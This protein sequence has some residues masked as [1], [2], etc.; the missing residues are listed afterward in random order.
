MKVYLASVR[1][2]T[3]FRDAAVEAVRNLNSAMGVDF[4]W[5]IYPSENWGIAGDISTK[6]LQILDVE[7]VLID[8]TPQVHSMPGPPIRRVV[9]FNPD[10]MTEYGIAFGLGKLNPS[11]LGMSNLTQQL[12]RPAHKI[13]CA[14]SYPRHDLPAIANGEDVESYD[15]DPG[16]RHE[17]VTKLQREIGRNIGNAL[18]PDNPPLQQPIPPSFEPRPI[19]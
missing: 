11:N 1:T 16:Q 9:D 5:L 13:F 3:L 10:V 19:V 17:L 12:R 15:P 8:M 18:N 2:N 6:I 7:L 4:I 14:T